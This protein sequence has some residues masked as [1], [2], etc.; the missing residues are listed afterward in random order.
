PSY[1]AG[2]PSIARAGTAPRQSRTEAMVKRR[3]NIGVTRKHM[4]RAHGNRKASLGSLGHA[5]VCGSDNLGQPLG[6]TQSGELGRHNP[7]GF[8]KFFV[9]CSFARNPARRKAKNDE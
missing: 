5:V 6:C 2:P 7:A 3:F 1:G 9:R 8:S 4:S